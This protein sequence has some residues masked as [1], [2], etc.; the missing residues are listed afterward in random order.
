[1][2]KN[3]PRHELQSALPQLLIGA[4]TDGL[5]AKASIFDLGAGTACLK[6]HNAAQSRN[7]IV[8]ERIAALQR[9]DGGD[10]M[11][12]ARDLGLSER[13]V[14]LM[15][16]PGGCGKLS[17]ADLDRFAAGAP[18]MSVGFVSTAGGVLLVAQLLRYLHL[19]VA[20][21]TA[22]GAMTVATFAR[23]RLRSLHMGRDRGCDCEPVLRGRW[24]AIWPASYC[25]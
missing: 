4:S 15:L 1:V 14:E 10:R 3:G 19:G 22:D 18:E 16:S 6:C 17:E 7:A 13:D 11:D 12:L 5:S 8:Q 21:A 23:A 9:L 24:C 2:D 20:A 25:P